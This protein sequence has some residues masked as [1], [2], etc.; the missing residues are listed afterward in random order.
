M[1][2]PIEDMTY[3]EFKAYCNARAC[4][5]NWSLVESLG[6]I[7]IMEEINAIKVKVLGITLKKR[8]EQAQEEAWRI[9]IKGRATR[10]IK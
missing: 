1:D 5:G 4:D 7:A 6:C 8:T 3:K 2:K 9:R 10:C